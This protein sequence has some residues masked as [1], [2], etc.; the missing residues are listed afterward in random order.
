MSQETALPSDGVQEL[1]VTLQG[2]LACEGV[3]DWG[4]AF[5]CALCRTGAVEWSARP[6]ATILAALHS[7]QLAVASLATRCDVPGGCI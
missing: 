6:F 2:D 7:G 4:R 3:S 5:E 1:A